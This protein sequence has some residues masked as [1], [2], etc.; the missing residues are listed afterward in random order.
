[1]NPSSP[2]LR[3]LAGV[4][5]I[6]AALRLIWILLEPLIPALIVIGTAVA[7]VQAVRWWRG[8]DL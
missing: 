7:V 3:F 2:W 5:A 4:V 8:D 1:V 6:A